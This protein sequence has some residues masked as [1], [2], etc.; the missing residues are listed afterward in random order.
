M[1]SSSSNFLHQINGGFVLARCLYVTAEIGVADALDETPLTAAEIASSVGAHPEALNRVLRLLASHGIFQVQGDKYVHSPSSRLLRSD[2]PQSIRPNLRV[3]GSPL[4][5]ETYGELEYTLRTGLPAA[6]KVTPGGE[7]AYRAAHPEANRLFNQ[8]METR[9][10]S[11]IAGFVAAYDC[12]GFHVIGDI[13]GGHGHLLMAVLERTPSARGVLFDQPHVIAEVAD[14]ASERFILKSGD[15]FKSDFPTCDAY[16]LMDIL[17]DWSD[18]DSLTI[19]KAIHRAAPPDAKLLLIERLITADSGPDWTNVLD[20][21]MMTL[22]G[23]KQRTRHEYETLFEQAGFLVEREIATSTGVSILEA[24][25][26]TDVQAPFL[27]KK[28]TM[29]SS[30]DS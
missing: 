25:C 2:H 21:H 16:L 27:Q 29:T 4:T 12:S 6:E 15:F 24:T 14:Q 8:S 5:W 11:Q 7:W 19:L 13:G 3:W 18:A 30:A 20:I 9:A 22:F 28:T 17:H 23:G 1:E 26:Q 10:R